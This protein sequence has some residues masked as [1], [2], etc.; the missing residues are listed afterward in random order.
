MRR[1]VFTQTS[2]D[3]IVIISY[4]QDNIR[5]SQFLRESPL[6]YGVWNDSLLNHEKQPF[7]CLLLFIK[8]GCVS[9][10]TSNRRNG[11]A[12]IES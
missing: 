6:E 8:F 3:H 9:R 7:A 5:Y 10:F 2:T 1:L 12:V 4:F 11:N